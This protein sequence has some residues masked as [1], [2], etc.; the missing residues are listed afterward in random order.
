MPD[1]HVRLIDHAGSWALARAD[2]GHGGPVPALASRDRVV[3]LSARPETAGA[4]TVTE[5]LE[6]WEAVLPVLEA[7]AANIRRSYAAC[8]RAAYVVYLG[9]EPNSPFD[10]GPPFAVVES[11]PFRAIYRLEAGDSAKSGWETKSG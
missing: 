7:V 3:D 10:C 2:L 11:A 1:T 4:R 9:R 6:H 5:L 8:P